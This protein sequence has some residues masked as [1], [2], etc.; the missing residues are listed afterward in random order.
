MTLPLWWWALP[1][2]EWTETRDATLLVITY[3]V[4]CL[5]AFSVIAVYSNMMAKWER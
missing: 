4:I 2:P 3:L 1:W 5:A